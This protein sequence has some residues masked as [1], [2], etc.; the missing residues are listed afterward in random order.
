MYNIPMLY[1]YQNMAISSSQPGTI[2][3]E[4]TKLNLFFERYLL[5]KAM[6]RFKF[7]LPETFVKDYF[8]SIL[9]ITGHI[10]IIETDKFGIIPQQ[11]S[12]YGYGVQYQPTKI[13]IANHL[14]KTP[15]EAVIDKNCTLIKL[16]PDYGGILDLISNYAN[17]M[18]LALTTAMLNL[19]NTKLSYVFFAK[20]KAAAET[21]KKLYDNIASGQPASVIDKSLFSED[22][23]PLWQMF[24][25]NLKANYICGDVLSDLRKIEQEFDTKVGIPNA[26]TDKKERLISDEVNANNVETDALCYIWYEELAE[27]FKKTRDLFGLSE[28]E[29][30]VKLRDVSEYGPQR[31]IGG[32]TDVRNDTRII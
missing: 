7:K 17:L 27:G 29:F 20:D 8:R 30:S 9:F 5:Q 31:V 25:Q 24:E 26:N 22:G 21:F 4:N 6:Y 3:I 10:G 14:I 1:D 18:S 13:N 28:E 32:D 16:T 12:L 23:R 2:K 11:C 19:L 15:I